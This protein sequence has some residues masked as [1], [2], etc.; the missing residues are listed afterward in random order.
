MT[1]DR[2]ILLEN[3][4]LAMPGIESGNVVLQGSDA[5][6]FHEG[7]LYTYNDSISVVVPLEQTGL[8]EE[9]IEG[10]VH[11]KELYNV[12]SKFK[13]DEINFTLTK[14]NTLLIKSG[15][16]KVEMNFLDFDYMS[17]IEGI[18]TEED[19]WEDLPEDFG[20]A[21]ASCRMASNKSKFAGVFVNGD[22]VLS[23][24]G[25][26]I[27]VYKM[28]SQLS[29]FYISDS[30]LNE[31]LKLKG[32]KRVQVNRTWVHFE[33]DHNV[34]FSAKTLNAKNL[35][36][37]KIMAVMDSSSPTDEDF[38]ATF[39][40]EVFLAIERADNFALDIN[41]DSVVRLTISTD[42]IGV[43]SEKASG[44]YNEEIEWEKPIEGNFE[45]TIV[46]VNN[47]MMQTMGM[48]SLEFYIKNMIDKKGRS[49]PRFLFVTESSKHLMNTVLV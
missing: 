36:F 12:I 45:P 16:A 33:T 10:G 8:V 21:L 40:L 1:I 41:N 42:K 17:R 3:L 31:L 9:D 18:S 4:K 2:K 38:H 7:K 13:S 32:L 48:H 39:P 15:K 43:S 23:T 11:A 47:T 34:I 14:D 28:K 25:F 35:P 37:D 44:K 5:F 22:V 19:K 49:V 20:D 30:T 29:E 46:Y 6:I 27:H 26:Q 24:D